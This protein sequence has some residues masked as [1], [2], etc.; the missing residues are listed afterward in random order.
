MPSPQPNGMV[1][2]GMGVPPAPPVAT[3]DPP[4]PPFPPVPVGVAPPVPPWPPVPVVPPL[5]PIGASVGTPASCGLLG[6]AL[7]PVRHLPLTQQPSLHVLPAQQMSPRLPHLAQTLSVPLSVQAVPD[8]HG[9]VAVPAG[10]HAWPIPP[11]AVHAPFLQSRP[12]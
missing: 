9:A 8:W 4:T 11:Q 7:P 3:V 12:S 1:V 2:L 10:Q 6:Q 5:P